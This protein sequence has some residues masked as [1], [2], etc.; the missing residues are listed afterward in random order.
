[1][2]M[3]KQTT[4]ALACVVVLSA[5]VPGVAGY[6]TARMEAIEAAERNLRALEARLQLREARDARP[7]S[8]SVPCLRTPS[9][10]QLQEFSASAL[11]REE[12]AGRG[13]PGE[14]APDWL[15]GLVQD[16]ERVVRSE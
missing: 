6:L 9:T 16:V 3:S 5:L 10:P 12:H 7:V 11:G 1:M 4:F 15:P 14:A 8:Y 2:G 13:R